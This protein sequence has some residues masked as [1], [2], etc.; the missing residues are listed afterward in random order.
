[1]NQLTSS[2]QINF[3]FIVK[4]LLFSHALMDRLIS[5][6]LE[7]SLLEIKSQKDEVIRM[8]DDGKV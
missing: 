3:S 1:L 4:T 2:E 7:G 5:I 6:V 8:E